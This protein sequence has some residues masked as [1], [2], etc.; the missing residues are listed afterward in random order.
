MV[1]VLMVCQVQ[2]W[3]SVRGWASSA[4]CL[5]QH[6]RDTVWPLVES[7]ASNIAIGPWT[8]PWLPSNSL[9]APSGLKR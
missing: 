6:Y 5:R 2:I 1:E 9:D 4:Q 3:W 8:P 7:G